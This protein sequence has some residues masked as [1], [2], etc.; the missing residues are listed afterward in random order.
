[1]T[2]QYCSCT[3]CYC[4][5]IF[6]QIE[7]LQPIVN[8]GDQM[9]SQYFFDLVCTCFLF[10]PYRF[11]SSRSS[12]EL[13]PSSGS[14]AAPTIALP[15]GAKGNMLLTLVQTA[16]R[17][18]FWLSLVPV[19]SL[20]FILLSKSLFERKAFGFP[21]RFKAFWVLV[22]DCTSTNKMREVVCKMHRDRV[23]GCTGQLAEVLET[24]WNKTSAKCTRN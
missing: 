6:A 23:P 22:P 8:H 9:T 2:V 15:C 18:D 19:L 21:R 4:Q 7:T 12:L 24:S 16:S 11:L 3:F 17:M 10:D 14:A 5:A 13:L 20:V 1:M